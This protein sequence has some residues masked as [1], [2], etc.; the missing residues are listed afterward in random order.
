MIRAPHVCNGDTST[1]VL[2]HIRL[3]GISGAGLKAPDVLATFGC[4]DCHAVCDG[5]KSSDFGP[6][7]RRQMLLEGMART[8]Y[9]LIEHGYLRW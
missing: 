5:Q 4:S 8:Q 6:G 1:T 3:I 9:W 2:C 7:E